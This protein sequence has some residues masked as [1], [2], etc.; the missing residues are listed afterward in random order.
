MPWII[1]ILGIGAL[2]ALLLPKYVEQK[3]Q[4]VLNELGISESVLKAMYAA[5]QEADQRLGVARALVTTQPLAPVTTKQV[6][7]ASQANQLASR[8]TAEF[9]EAVDRFVKSGRSHPSLGVARDE[10]ANMTGRA[11]WREKD[12]DELRTLLSQQAPTSQPPLK[13]SRSPRER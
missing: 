5:H 1:A 8:R 7:A 13:P 4:E 2:A 6:A 10:V 9:A 3:G 11:T 12:I